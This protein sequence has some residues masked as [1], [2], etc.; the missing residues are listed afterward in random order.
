MLAVNFTSR[1]E[2]KNLHE[3]APW[4][5]FCQNDSLNW[6]FS[7]CDK[8]VFIYQNNSQKVA[9]FTVCGGI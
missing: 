2:T 4:K 7:S 5:H 3:K 6:W 9:N 1:E 8:N